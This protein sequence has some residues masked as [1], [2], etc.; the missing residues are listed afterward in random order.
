MGKIEPPGFPLKLLKWFCKPEYHPDIEG[1]LLELFDRQVEKSGLKKAKWLLLKDVLLLF[2]LGIIRSFKPVHKL[3]LYDMIKENL[4][5]AFRQ[6]SKQKGFAAIKIGGFALGVVAFILIVLFIKDELSYDQHYP[7]LDRIY[8]IYIEY[9]LEENTIS[10]ASHP[11]PLAAA[12]LDEF[13]EVESTARFNAWP[14]LE[15]PGN[16]NFRRADQE[17]NT[18]EEGFIYADQSLLDI[19]QFPFLYG[20]ASTA[21]SEPN[22][23]VITEEKATKY[24][25]NENPLGKTIILNNNT[26]KPFKISGVLADGAAKSHI[27]YNF[28]LSL[29]NHE[30]WPGEQGLWSVNFYDCYLKLKPN[31]DAI[32]FEKKLERIVRNHYAV[33]AV[34][35]GNAES[36]D[37]FSARCHLRLQPVNEVYLKTTSVGIRDNLIHGDIRLVWFLGIIAIFIL[38][39]A[40][41]NF[42]NLTTARSANR[43]KEVG[44]RKVL[45]SRRHTLVNQFLTESLLYSV[46]A[47]MIGL[48]TAGLLLPFF[49]QMTAKSIVMPW[50]EGWFFPSLILASLFIGLLAGIYPAFYLSSFRPMEALKG[51]WARGVEGRSLQNVLVVF[52]FTIT[53]V[54]ITATILIN[55]QMSFILNKDLGFEK[56]QVILLEGTQ[57]LGEK[58]HT[59]KENLLQLPEVKYVSISDFLP[60]KGGKRYGNLMWVENREDADQKVLV[61]RWRVDHDYIKT[62][63]MQLLTGRDFN[64]E[65]PTDSQAVI[66]NQRLVEKMNLQDPIGMVI[67]EGFLA[68]TKIIGVVEDFHF[69]SFKEE[70]TPLC[71]VLDDSNSESISVKVSSENVNALLAGLTNTWEKFLPNQPIRYNFLDARFAAAYDDIKRIGWIISCFS[72]LAIALACLGL[73]ALAAF[74]AE[75]RSKEMSIR[76]VLGASVSTIFRLLTQHFLL[77]ILTSLGIAT[78]LAWY[79][80][81]WWLENYNYRVDITMDIFVFAG[82]IVLFIALLTISYQAMKAA[83]RNPASVMQKES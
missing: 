16:N 59:L 62:M 73:F 70:I 49:N 65:M 36:I 61:Q 22:T 40:A 17:Q 77:L 50:G 82:I 52:Q 80:M 20:E 31:T 55:R 66:V 53:I 23:I 32:A 26:N 39:L 41:I 4:K 1:D 24:F 9:N 12:I 25:P 3:N 15:G 27:Q 56:D 69:E 68:P 29:T 33:T 72:I 21:L 13:P 6:M 71:L 51:Q 81:K 45:G 79:F 83:V 30:F 8:R 67:T 5:T 14:D 34:E 38:L 57:T 64:K 43:A 35:R 11:P 60:V 76:K 10:G 19:F 58:V 78:P 44:L 37:A 42:I 18:Y 54:L 47:F 2:R 75:Q 7:D 46:L 48:S 63:G 74:M 28:F